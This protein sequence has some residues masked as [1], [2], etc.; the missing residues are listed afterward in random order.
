MGLYYEMPASND[1]LSVV[2]VMAG[3]SQRSFDAQMKDDK[4]CLVGLKSF[5]F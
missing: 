3:Y 1:K 2:D 4:S 5:D